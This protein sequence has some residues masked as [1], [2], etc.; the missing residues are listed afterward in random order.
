MTLLEGGTWVNETHILIS[1]F[2]VCVIF[3]EG[4]VSS[5]LVSIQ[6]KASS[7]LK[8]RSYAMTCH[9]TLCTCFRLALWL[10]MIE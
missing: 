6:V 4:S 10:E 7:I 2:G 1:V 3:I 5:V 8:K 9:W